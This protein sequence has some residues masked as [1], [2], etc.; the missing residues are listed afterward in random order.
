MFSEALSQ[1]SIPIS[2]IHEMYSISSAA[3]CLALHC[4]VP[5]WTSPLHAHPCYLLPRGQEGAEGQSTSLDTDKPG[6][7]CQ[8]C[9]LLAV[10]LGMLNLSK[11]RIP[12]LYNGNNNN[13][14]ESYC[15]DLL[16]N[17]QSSTRH[18]VASHSMG[19]STRC[20]CSSV[21]PIL[22]LPLHTHA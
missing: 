6:C 22:I 13:I 3:L 5:V 18:R 19:R 20:L 2:S 4:T 16:R 10:R 15:E 17:T 14:P 8:L 12:Q 11:F 7:E 21:S 9:C 1:L